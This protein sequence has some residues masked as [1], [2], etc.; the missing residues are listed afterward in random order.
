MI[1]WF[2]LENTKQSIYFGY[3]S[4]LI[5][6]SINLDRFRSNLIAWLTL[7]NKRSTLIAY[8]STL[9]DCDQRWSIYRSTLIVSDQSWSHDWRVKINDQPWSFSINVDRFTDQ[10]WSFPINLDRLVKTWEKTINLDRLSINV[11]R[12][13]STLIEE[14]S[15]L[16]VLSFLSKR[17]RLIAK[18]IKVD[19][20][21]SETFESDRYT[22]A[23]VEKGRWSI[24]RFTWNVDLQSSVIHARLFSM[25]YRIS[26]WF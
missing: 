19:R 21:R 1:I 5:D 3:R 7:E 6:L 26:T 4:T 12:F 10:P 16:I 15:R 25:P 11:D 17:S 8:R 22:P 24:F 9:I 2:V 18:S 23:N 13:R 20:K 14:R